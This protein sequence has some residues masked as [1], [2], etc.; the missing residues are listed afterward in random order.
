[1]HIIDAAIDVERELGCTIVPEIM[2]PLIGSEAE[3][4]Y[5]KDNVTKA[6]EAA[7]M[8]KNEMCIRDS[9]NRC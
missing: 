6:I 5:V 4:V 2:L 1:M 7:I 8:A 9:N 3:I